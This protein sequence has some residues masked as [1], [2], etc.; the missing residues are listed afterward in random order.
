ML[1]KECNIRE[2][3]SIFKVDMCIFCHMYN[4]LTRWRNHK[5]RW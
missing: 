4:V 2:D 5:V 1:C 3:K